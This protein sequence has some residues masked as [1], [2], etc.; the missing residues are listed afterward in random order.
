LVVEDKKLKI[1]GRTEMKK[2]CFGAEKDGDSG[3]R[4]SILGRKK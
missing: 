2:V 1:R 3:G 4:D